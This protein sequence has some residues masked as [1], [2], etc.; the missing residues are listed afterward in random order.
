MRAADIKTLLAGCE[1]DLFLRI[2]FDALQQVS[3]DLYGNVTCGLV[4]S[5]GKLSAQHP[6]VV[7]S[8]PLVC[9]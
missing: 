3:E 1:T 4:S 8:W 9:Y 5:F 2:T 6:L 7:V